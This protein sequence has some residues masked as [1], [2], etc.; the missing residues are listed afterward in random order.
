MEHD[1][2]PLLEAMA[3]TSDGVFVVDDEY[4]IT[5]WNDEA[6]QILG[7]PAEDVVG[8]TCY[9]VLHGLDPSGNPYCHRDCE[10][11][12]CTLLAS[13]A[14]TYDLE[15]QHREG[16]RVWVNETII[17][18]PPGD[19]AAR[20]VHLF[21]NVTRQ[22]R[23]QVLAERVVETVAQLG[24]AAEEREVA[25]SGLHPVLTRRELEVLQLL[26]GGLKTEGIAE[27]LKISPLTARNHIQRILGKLGVQRRSEAVAYAY[28][29]RLA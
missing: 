19:G 20:A 2:D 16:Q 22:R 1:A 8:R 17:G 12:L 23:A 14:P 25:L 9:D 3:R 28:R 11:M 10:P 7:F 15:T 6:R 24:P 13:K 26:A 5:F 4:R 21:R 29:H 27:R 18:F